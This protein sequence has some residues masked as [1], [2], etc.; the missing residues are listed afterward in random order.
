MQVRFFERV[1]LER[2]IKQIEGKAHRGHVLSSEEQQQ[3]KQ[4]SENLQVS[5]VT[6]FVRLH[7]CSV[8]ESGAHLQY[9]LHFPKGERYVSI[10]KSADE[11]AAQEQL[12][13]ERTRLHTI[14]KRQLAESAMLAEAD[15]GLGQSQVG[16]QPDTFGEM[17]TYALAWIVKASYVR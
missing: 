11:P 2:R 8:S 13:A 17:I 5:K 10:L 14:I 12:E 3:L 9:V 1:K 15:E 16:F 7:C 4:H 6:A